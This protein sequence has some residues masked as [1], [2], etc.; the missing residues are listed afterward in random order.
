MRDLELQ[1]ELAQQEVRRRDVA[2]ER[3]EHG[4][5]AFLGREV[6]R[7]GGLVV[8][9]QPPE[10]VDF[11][12]SV[13]PRLRVVERAVG[14]RSGTRRLRVPRRLVAGVA[15]VEVDVGY[16]NDFATPDERPRLGDTRHGE[17]Q[18]EVVRD[19]VAQQPLQRRVVEDLPP[20]HDQPAS[21][22]R[23]GRRPRD[24]PPAAAR[25]GRL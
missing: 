21:R 13:T 18:I 17:P 3:D 23:P 7:E 20:R 12:R 10:Q 1:V 16:R 8:A 19:R 4:P 14:V 2:H 5:A 6:P 9:A 25:S 11:P 24:R 15:G 22:P